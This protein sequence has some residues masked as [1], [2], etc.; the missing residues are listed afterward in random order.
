M[1]WLRRT[2]SMMVAHAEMRPKVAELPMMYV[3]CDARD[4]RTLM[5]LPNFKKSPS[6]SGL[7]LT[8]EITTTLAASP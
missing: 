1:L 4:K 7:H 2:M 8:S 5:R 3:P 6:F